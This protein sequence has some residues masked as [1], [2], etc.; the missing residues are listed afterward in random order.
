MTSLH[1]YRHRRCFYSQ[2][3]LTWSTFLTCSYRARWKRALQLCGFAAL[4]S[5]FAMKFP[6]R[7]RHERHS[8]E[9]GGISLRTPM[10][11]SLETNAA[12][13]ASATGFASIL[14]LAFVAVIG[15]MVTGNLLAQ[16]ADEKKDDKKSET[17]KPVDKPVEKAAKPTDAGKSKEPVPLNAQGTV[18]LD[19]PGKRLLLKSKVCLQEGV[20]EMF[21]CRKLS[22][23]HI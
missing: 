16:G 8:G 21:A 22:L 9:P 6:M 10:A 17:T 1:L 11:Q 14:R 20:L 5:L 13:V 7:P 15:F 3:L 4:S 23:I 2:G 18:L 19:V 12:R